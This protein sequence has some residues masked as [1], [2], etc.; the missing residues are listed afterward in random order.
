[1]ANLNLFTGFEVPDFVRSQADMQNLLFS[2][3]LQL[4]AEQTLNN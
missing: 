3:S 4:E 2:F 1:M